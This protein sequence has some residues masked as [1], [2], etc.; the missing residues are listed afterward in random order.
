MG[1]FGAVLRVARAGVTGSPRSAWMAWSRATTSPHVSGRWRG[2]AWSVAVIRSRRVAGTSGPSAGGSERRTRAMVAAGGSSR[3]PPNGL[4]PASRVWRVAPRA[5]TS[6]VGP[7][8]CPDSTSGGVKVMVPTRVPV[9]VLVPSERRAMP[10]SPSL[11][12]PFSSRSTLAGLTSRWRIPA[13]WAAARASATWTPT[14][15]TSGQGRAPSRWRRSWSEPPGRCSMTRYGWPSSVVPASCTVTTA[16]WPESRPM[17]RHS[18]MKRRSR[19]ESDSDSPS[20]F[21]ATRRPSRPCSAS[22]TV[23]NPPEPSFSTST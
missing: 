16:G 8:R 22:Q 18:A 6:A 5:H 17:A 2:S 19:S 23:A 9:A 10:K 3:W 12:E 20:S 21:T 11:G 15:R 7:G 1:C 4:R 14:S 13:S